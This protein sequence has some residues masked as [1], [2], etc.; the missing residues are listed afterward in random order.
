M[1]CRC[2]WSICSSSHSLIYLEL[3]E[4]ACT[5]TALHIK[6]TIY[7]ESILVCGQIFISFQCYSELNCRSDLL[8]RFVVFIILWNW[9][10][11]YGSASTRCFYINLFIVLLSILWCGGRLWNTFACTCMTHMSRVWIPVVCVKMIALTDKLRLSCGL[12]SDVSC[13]LVPKY[14]NIRSCRWR[15]KLEGTL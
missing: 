15:L 14:L 1:L 13:L 4:S 5:F 6:D 12:I 11:L 8:I 9:T 3:L 10:K 7:L 2:N